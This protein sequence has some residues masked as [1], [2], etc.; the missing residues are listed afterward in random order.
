M[1]TSPTMTSTT[2]CRTNLSPDDLD[3]LLTKLR[4]LDVEIVMDQAE[5]ERA[6]RAK[7]PEQRSRRK[8]MRT[9]GSKFS[10]I[11]CACT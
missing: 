5:A 10:T 1:A 11:R 6:E 4:A 9:R 7:Q 2:F 3:V 8:P